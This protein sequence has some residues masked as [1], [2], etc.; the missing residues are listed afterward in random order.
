MGK[1]KRIG[2]KKKRISLGIS[3]WIELKSLKQGSEN[4][5][6]VIMKLIKEHKDKVVASY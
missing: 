4:Y 6:S 3:T 5:S 1:A 2:E